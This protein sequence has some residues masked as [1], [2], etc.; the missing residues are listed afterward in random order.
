MQFGV[1]ITKKKKCPPTTDSTTRSRFGPAFHFPLNKGTRKRCN[2]HLIVYNS[3]STR[4][5]TS[6]REGYKHIST[7]ILDS[8]SLVR[9]LYHLVNVHRKWPNVCISNGGCNY[10]I[11]PLVM[12]YELLQVSES[13]THKM[14]IGEGNKRFTTTS[15]WMLQN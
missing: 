12:I 10:F 5:L 9:L 6:T 11:V 1:I 14:N 4:F 2:D 13:P 15:V 3:G 7:N 8:A